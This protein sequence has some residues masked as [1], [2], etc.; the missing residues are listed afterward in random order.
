VVSLIIIVPDCPDV[1]GSGG[2]YMSSGFS[3]ISSRI[4]SG[5][6]LKAAS[7]VVVVVAAAVAER[8]T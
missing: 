2:K 4:V 5:D 6:P 7:L 8:G 3:A 1:V